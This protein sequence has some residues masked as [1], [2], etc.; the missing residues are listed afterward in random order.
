MQLIINDPEKGG[1]YPW[2]NAL[3]DRLG[4]N[5]REYVESLLNIYN[6]SFDED[7][8]A[9]LGLMLR[10]N[11]KILNSWKED[12]NMSML[13]E[14]LRR[15]FAPELAEAVENGE[16][17]G[18]EIGERRGDANRSKMVAC[19]MYQR[20]FTAEEA[21]GLIGIKPEEVEAWYKEMKAGKG[22]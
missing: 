2:L 7:K 3:T 21:A 13:Q 4:E 10:A 15:L 16:K 8:E 1:P 6:Q 22:I 17:R 19:N 11:W 5:D 14:E 9:V 20:G 12:E 18:V